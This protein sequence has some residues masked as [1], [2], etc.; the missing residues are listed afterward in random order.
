M[1]P[2]ESSTTEAIPIL[3]LNPKQ[4]AKSLG[5]SERTL[6]TYTKSGLIPV[7]RIGHSVRYSLEALR[8]LIGQ[9]TE[10]QHESR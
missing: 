5:I 10:R 7:V 8:A 2:Q 6:A 3:L 9:A 1:M 4:A